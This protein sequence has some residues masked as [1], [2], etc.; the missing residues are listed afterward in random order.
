MCGAL[1]GQDSAQPLTQ[2]MDIIGDHRNHPAKPIEGWAR[3]YPYWTRLASFLRPVRFSQQ[4]RHSLKVNE[5]DAAS[6]YACLQPGRRREECQV[7]QTLP[8]SPPQA[9]DYPQLGYLVLLSKFAR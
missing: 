6:H 1:P 3:Q 9:E 7:L 5:C 8:N 2:S 4:S